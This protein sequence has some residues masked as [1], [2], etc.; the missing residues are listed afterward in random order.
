MAQAAIGIQQCHR[1]VLAFHDG[2][3]SHVEVSAVAQLLV[4]DQHRDPVGVDA[5]QVGVDHCRCGDSGRFLR[6]SPRLEHAADLSAD[7]LFAEQLHSPLLQPWAW[8]GRTTPKPAEIPYGVSQ[9]S[10]RRRITVGALPSK[11]TLILTQ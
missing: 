5:G 1:G 2:L 10:F 9:L 8:T 6:H 11:P 3:G 7:C 4:G